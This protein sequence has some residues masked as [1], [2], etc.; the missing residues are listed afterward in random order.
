MK[1]MAYPAE[2]A[3]VELFCASAGGEQWGEAE[4]RAARWLAEQQAG[5]D[6]AVHAG[7]YGEASRLLAELAASGRPC[8]MVN[9]L[10]PPTGRQLRDVRDVGLVV[11]DGWVGRVKEATETA[12]DYFAGNPQPGGILL[13]MLRPGVESYLERELV[14]VLDIVRIEGTRLAV[15]DLAQLDPRGPQ[16][17]EHYHWVEHH[18]DKMYES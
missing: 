8:T 18:P 3:A 17:E 9:L 16:E 7:F 2:A 15:L 11:V 4:L 14:R 13:W 12:L 6:I 10:T 1:R 5:G